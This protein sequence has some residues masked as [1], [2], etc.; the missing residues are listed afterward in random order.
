M[1]SVTEVYQCLVSFWIW[2]KLEY[3]MK[4][5]N[6]GKKHF[7]PAWFF[8][9]VDNL[10][11]CTLTKSSLTENKTRNKNQ[12]IQHKYQNPSHS[13]S[14]EGYNLSFLVCVFLEGKHNQHNQQ[15]FTKPQALS[16]CL[17]FLFSF[18][19]LFFPPPQLPREEMN[20]QSELRRCTLP[21]FEKNLWNNVT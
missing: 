16:P 5:L 3:S 21:T 7:T 19:S 1:D 14:N 18:L 10:F 8:P 17:A 2:N 12:N 15:H 4:Y 6:H 20:S 9:S 13:V 11:Y